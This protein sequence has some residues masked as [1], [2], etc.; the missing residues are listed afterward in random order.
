VRANEYEKIKVQPYAGSLGAEIS[1][2]D[3][4]KPLPDD[5]FDEIRRAF[6]EN[7]V[8]FIVGQ[9]LT[10]DHQCDFARRFGHLTKH[11]YYQTMKNYPEVLHMLRKAHKMRKS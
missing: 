10:A 1:G 6:Q 9:D 7:L 11:P 5:V 2:V 3:L 8:V 4:R